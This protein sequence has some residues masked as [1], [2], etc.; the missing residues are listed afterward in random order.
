MNPR[1]LWHGAAIAMASCVSMMAVVVTVSPAPAGADGDPST[2]SGQGGSFLEPVVSK[3]IAD[4]APNLSPIFGAY[5]VT[6]INTG[7]AS[8]V[9][10]APGQFGADYAVSERPLTAAE[11]ATAKANGRSFAYIPFAETPVAIATLVPTETWQAGG[12]PVIT[13]TDFC[14]NVPLTTELLGEIFGFDK[15]SPLTNWHDPRITCPPAGPSG[16]APNSIYLWANLDPSMA[17]SALMSL[18]DS[19]PTSKAFLDAGLIE[20]GMG[21]LTTD[22]TPSEFWPYGQNT[23][24]GGD[25]PLIGKLLNIGTKTNAPSQTASEWQLGATLP[26]SSVWT[27]APHGVPWNL[28]TAAVQNADNQFVAPSTAAAQAAAADAALAATTDPTT[29]NLVTFNA[30]ATDAAAYNNF[31]ME[32]SYLVVPTSG[33]SAAKAK[34]LAQLVRF[35]LG[36]QGQ[37]DIKTFGAAPAT[38]AMVTAGLRVAVTLD[39]EAVSA[40]AQASTV[41]ATTSATTSTTAPASAAAASGASTTGSTDTG[42]SG[43]GDSGSG[44]AYTGGPDLVAPVGIGVA[45]VLIATLYRRRLRH[46]EDSA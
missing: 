46:R 38:T 41:T 44:L 17:N 2:L 5:S 4:D 23:I 43:T 32:E 6:D 19:T 35:A 30:S 12:S 40:A 20:N 36:P 33:L 26:I 24:P 8:F 22:D 3:L 28:A 9:G 31:L 16:A 45:L 25:Q 15:A 27:G 18:L 1:V 21:G 14:Q 10:T 37:Q 42:S 7:I 29:N 13:S 11:A 34:A 39:S